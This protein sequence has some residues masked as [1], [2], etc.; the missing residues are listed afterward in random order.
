MIHWLQRSGAARL[1]ARLVVERAEVTHELL[2]T[3]PQDPHTRYIRELLVTVGIL[4]RRHEALERIRLWIDK[5]VAALPPHQAR[6]VRPFAEWHVLKTAR[7]AV[8]RGRYTAGS[9]S[10]D[11]MEIR[12]TIEFL[13]WLDTGSLALADVTQHDFDRWL[14][15]TSSSRRRG[16]TP[17]IRWAGARRLSRQL[18]LAPCK[19]GNPS[20]FLDEDE[21]NA[22][23][24]RCLN[25]DTLPL[26][27]RITGSLIRLYALSAARISELTVDGFCQDETGSYFTFGN[28][29][30]LLP[31]KLAQLIEEQI[32]PRRISLFIPTA[33]DD[34][35]FLFPGNPASRPRSA[36]SVRNLLKQHGLLTL[37]ARNTAMIAMISDMPPKVVSDLLGLSPDTTTQWAEYL[38][39]SWADY[40]AAKTGFIGECEC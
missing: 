12:H 3:L 36:H 9:A 19:S 4:P 17:F 5:T 18:D 29:P 6:I 33:E 11:R 10:N 31:P 14:S 2:D 24:H 35:G 26:E 27:V 34:P 22:Q 8:A 1:L 28:E 37:A 21:M 30:V 23:L 15:E 32:A 40:L 13:T 38:Q 20:Q 39:D 16:I 7:R 25:D